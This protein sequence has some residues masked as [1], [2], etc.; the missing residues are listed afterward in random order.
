MINKFKVII[1]NI[2]DSKIVMDFKKYFINHNE[3]E[4]ANKMAIGTLI[5]IISYITYNLR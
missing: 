2:N 1:N 4:I 5:I 3:I